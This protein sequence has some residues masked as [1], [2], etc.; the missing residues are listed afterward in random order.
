[1]RA[2]LADAIEER[3]SLASSVLA[4]AEC[5]PGAPET[6]TKA[7]FPLHPTG[8]AGGLQVHPQRVLPH[9]EG[10]ANPPDLEVPVTQN[11]AG[12][13][14]GQGQRSGAIVQ[15]SGTVHTSRYPPIR[16]RVAGKS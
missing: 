3:Q 7:E 5:A 11:E 6:Q 12:F 14:R 13:R 8:I 15:G 10:T 4:R 2:Q 1:M 16:P 9:A